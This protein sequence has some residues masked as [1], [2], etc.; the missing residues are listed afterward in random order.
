MVASAVLLL[1]LGVV[2]S[3][4]SQTSTVTRQATSKISAFQGARAAFDLMT[5]NL[6]Q[7]TLNS[8]WD[9]DDPNAPTK[10]LRKSELHFLIGNAGSSPFGGT[11]GTGQAVYFQAPAGVT[12]K[13]DGLESLLDAVG[14]FVSYGNDD[15]LPSPFPPSE[16]FR[17]RLM[18]AI[19]PAE[20]LGVYSDTTGDDWALN[21]EQSAV[22]LAENI[23]YMV[24]WPRKAPTE[25]AQGDG[26]TSA[27]A[28]DSRSGAA[29][30]PKDP[31]TGQAITQHQMPPMVQISIFAMDETSAAR[32]CTGSTAPT[33]VSS[34]FTGLF[35]NSNQDDFDADILEATSRLGAKHINFRIFTAI[36]P[37]R[38]SKMQ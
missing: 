7:A 14:Y 30:L 9:Y 21:V 13:Y 15:A 22:P 23:F 19:Q 17:Y 33:D 4:I 1:M 12:T 35:Q 16:K 27:Y 10:Y 2:L 36:V 18:Q 26:L 3:T 31:I 34:A 8:Y 37:I 28:Y 38:E 20:D 25:D 32:V 6:G 29:S 11:P 5:E 24:A